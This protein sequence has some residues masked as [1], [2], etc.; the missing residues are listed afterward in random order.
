MTIQLRNGM[1]ISIDAAKKVIINYYSNM[2]KEEEEK[3]VH[4]YDKAKL[5]EDNLFPE[6]QIMQAI[7]LMYKLGGHGIP[8]KYV[9]LLIQKRC[10]IESQLQ[11]VPTKI[12]ILDRHDEIPWSELKSLFD[13]FR[14]PYVSI[15]RLTKILHK[16]RPN[17][18][19]ILDSVVV[20]KY[21]QPLLEK[22]GV[23]SIREETLRAV[24]CI[25]E[26]KKD[27]D[28]NKE[29]LTELQ[30]YCKKRWYD[31]SVIRVLDILLWSCLGPFKER[32]C[33]DC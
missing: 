24:Y 25:K 13:I 19:P 22:Q 23:A 7:G 32:L 8:H 28:T 14:I 18:I 33:K 6:H 17:M 21:L 2:G 20:G 30:N 15:P 29:A 9:Q 11:R 16:K 3:G 31:I 27:A 12:S 4:G 5:Q 1:M 26:L 10:E